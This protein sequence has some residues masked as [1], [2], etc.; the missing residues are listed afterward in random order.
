MLGLKACATTPGSN[1]IFN[2]GSQTLTSLAAHYSPEVV[3]KKG[4]AKLFR[5][6]L[7]VTP[8]CVVWKSAI[9]FIG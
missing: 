6:V 1:P 4:E 9:Q 7:W 8:V 5:K 2:D 3:E